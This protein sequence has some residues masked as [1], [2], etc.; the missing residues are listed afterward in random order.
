MTADS[1]SNLDP[2]TNNA[3][4]TQPR[5]PRTIANYLYRRSRIQSVL[6]Y[7][8]R[9]TILVIIPIAFG[10]LSRL[11]IDH[12]GTVDSTHQ[13]E[14]LNYFQNMNVLI[15]IGKDLV[16]PENQDF[17]SNYRL[18]YIGGNRD[19]LIAKYHNILVYF[20]SKIIKPYVMDERDTYAK[21]IIL[22]SYSKAVKVLTAVLVLISTMASTLYLWFA[23]LFF[24]VCIVFNLS[25]KMKSFT[26]IL[27]ALL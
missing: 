10:N 22:S 11:L 14:I 3:A 1:N 21:A 7:L 6:T 18:I 24:S 27:T 12:F 8:I 9:F 26:S 15:P 5:H 2:L 19:S 16:G 20:T 13:N 23:L 4:P 25:I 17:Q